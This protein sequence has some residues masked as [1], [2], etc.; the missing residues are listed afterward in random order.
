M[1]KI[2]VIILILSALLACSKP[3][4]NKQEKK[5][6]EEFK[7]KQG[8]TEVLFWYALSGPLGEALRE[9]VLEFNQ[10][11]P[12]IYINA[13]SMGNYT[14]LSQKLMASI[15]TD[16]QPDIAQVFESWTANLTAENKLVPMTDLIEQ[17]KSFTDQDLNDYFDVFIKSNTINNKLW[18]MPFNKSVRV[19]YYN[20]D[21][22]FLN[23][24]DP[25]K[26]PTTWDDFRL[27]CKA[28]TKDTD[29][30]GKTD[31]YGTTFPV[32]AW[33][34]ENLLL[35]A[36][37]E[38]MDSTYTKAKFNSP[39]GKIAV[40]FLNNLLNV[41]KTAYLST[42]YSGQD[43]FLAGKVAMVEGSSVSMAFMKKKGIDFYL[44]TGA[45][46]VD[47]TNKS[48]ISGT[49][50][51][52]FDKKSPEA[53]K[54]AWEFIKW[55]TSPAITARWSSKTYYMPVRK[56]AFNQPELQKRLANHPEVKA[57]YD[58]LY[59][60]SF[61]PPIKQ[62][63]KARKTIEEKVLER[64]LRGTVSA[65]KALNEAAADLEKALQK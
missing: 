47:K 11:N 65:E 27:L 30:D 54:A 46:P 20:G 60:A 10:T 12:D 24:R 23:G 31:I 21:M 61:E 48:I 51:A 14:A 53:A 26:P 55:F 16:T 43:D 42:G 36:G 7:P 9:L 41:D 25:Y 4:T 64:V 3:N 63:Y 22:L 58:Q 62:W 40:D 39:E 52:I 13:V 19:L 49:N 8:A 17:D 57:V 6:I 28:L 50:I 56:T 37:G 38:I 29:G 15:Q 34:F 45:I 44:G 1:R 5:V 35:Q 2:I 33:Q 59:S 32:S 18:T